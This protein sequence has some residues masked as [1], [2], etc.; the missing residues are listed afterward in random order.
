M[1]KPFPH[2]DSDSL[3]M[4]GGIGC[5]FSSAITLLVWR[6]IRCFSIHADASQI[7]QIFFPRNTTNEIGYQ[8]KPR[9]PTQ[10]SRP[11]S[12]YTFPQPMSPKSPV[13]FV[14]YHQQHQR[15]YPPIEVDCE[16]PCTA[17]RPRTRKDRI[18]RSLDF[19]VGLREDN[20][21]GYSEAPPYHQYPEE[22]QWEDQDLGE[23]REWEH[24]K[25]DV[26]MVSG[27]TDEDV[28]QLPMTVFE[29]RPRRGGRPSSLPLPTTNLHPYVRVLASTRR[30]LQANFSD[31]RSPPSLL[32]S[33]SYLKSG[34]R[35][36]T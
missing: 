21:S 4:L 32:P 36:K 16:F 24:P 34:E 19:E 9:P 8:V 35:D 3:F 17:S 1:S 23:R 29:A 25:I 20:V 28:P 5:F 31:C 18:F 7:R 30:S 33:V 6:H 10:N 11:Q 27:A 12:H 13:S 22:D 15:E 26:E 2:Y 14:Q